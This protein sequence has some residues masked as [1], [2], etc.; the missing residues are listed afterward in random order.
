MATKLSNLA[1]QQRTQT[2]TH[3][4]PRTHTHTNPPTNR[5]N[6]R[7]TD[8]PRPPRPHPRR[9]QTN[10]HH[11]PPCP[12][13]TPRTQ[14]SSTCPKNLQPHRLLSVGNQQ[15]QTP[16]HARA[17]MR[18]RF[19]QDLCRDVTWSGSSFTQAFRMRAKQFAY[20]R[21][22]TMPKRSIRYSCA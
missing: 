10:Y 18:R 2:H 3:T 5:L 17:Q 13:L 8:L 11:S 6:D 15:M 19:Q 12:K 4:H 14:L 22:L 21:L 16:A 7:P 20:L 9:K 1:R